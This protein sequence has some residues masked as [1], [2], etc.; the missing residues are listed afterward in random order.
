MAS[1]YEISPNVVYVTTLDDSDDDDDDGGAKADADGAMRALE[2]HPAFLAVRNSGG[3]APF[4]S[5]LPP[6]LVA[7]LRGLGGGG[8]EE[9]GLVLYRPL[10]FA[11]D[12]P[13]EREKRKEE[14]RE[15]TRA[16]AEEK[17]LNHPEETVGMGMGEEEVGN[18][19]DEDVDMMDVE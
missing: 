18:P 8:G 11:D 9:R 2:V 7:P 4:Q 12:G 17:K 6:E 15:Y 1:S 13:G 3:P 5:P 16:R 19:G 14:F 10:R